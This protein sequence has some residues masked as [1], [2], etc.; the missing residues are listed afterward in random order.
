[1]GEKQLTLAEKWQI[2]AEAYKKGAIN[3]TSV[4]QCAK[5]RYVKKGDALHCNVYK[6]ERK[7]GYVMFPHKECP[8]FCSDDILEVDVSDV[9]CDKI[10]GGVFGFLSYGIL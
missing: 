1:M 8:S 9:K 3:K 7:A 10:Y 6:E 2:D 5:C 4:P